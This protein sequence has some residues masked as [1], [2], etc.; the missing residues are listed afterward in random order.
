M[1]IY[2]VGILGC[3]RVANHYKFLLT[4]HKQ[5]KS[6]NIVA[7]CD[8]EDSFA[9]SLANSFAANPYNDMNIMLER[10]ELD[11]VLVLTP[12]GL[13]YEHCHKIL[14]RNVSVVVEKPICLIPE[15]A[16]ELDLLAKS[17]NIFISSVFQNR[18]NPSI[19]KLKS[20]MD[21]DGFGKLITASI[22]LRWCRYQ[23]YYEDGWH[24]TWKMDGGVLCQ[25]A[26]HHIDAL[27]WILGPV[28]S[29]CAKMS[30]QVNKLEA[31][32]TLVGIIKFKS[33]CLSTIEL[34][35]AARPKDF[36]ASISIVGDKGIAQ[37]GGIAL[38]KIDV[39]DFIN[40]SETL[41]HVS[42][43]FNVDVLNG[44]GFGH[45]DFLEDLIESIEK[46]LEKAPMQVPES[47]NA[48]ELVHALYA[49]VEE[50]KWIEMKENKRSKLLGL[51]KI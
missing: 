46:G 7:C 37:V 42:K 40:N 51:R 22:R 15:Q 2:K 43:S 33:G 41:E 39:W 11:F 3:N 23:D 50:E 29:V 19:V 27:R 1:K 26:I 36:E 5:I 38:N 17:K 31:E 12:S 24:G 13:H 34:T 45:V 48:L 30:N 35:T 21:S 20:H 28:E 49:S 10:E 8:L 9:S 32:D 4:K 16:F 6:L 25:Q 14:S 18:Y 44:M 47:T